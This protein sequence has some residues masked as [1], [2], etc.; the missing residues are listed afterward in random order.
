MNLVSK[1]LVKFVLKLKFA[2]PTATTLDICH[3]GV[4]KELTDFPLSVLRPLYDPQTV[5][6]GVFPKFKL[7]DVSSVLSFLQ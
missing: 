3:P 5:S 4:A 1:G 2:T 6:R 7:D